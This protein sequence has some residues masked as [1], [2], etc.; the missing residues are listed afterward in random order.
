V[1][2]GVAA[3]AALVK[4]IDILYIVL[5]GDVISLVLL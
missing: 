4:R 1:L 2:L 3:L 5:I